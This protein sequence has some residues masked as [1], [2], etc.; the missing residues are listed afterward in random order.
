MSAKVQKLHEE[1]STM[2]LSD[3][4]LLAHQAV[5]FPMPDEKLDLILKYVEMAISMR[6]IRKAQP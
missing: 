4:L 1:M 3:I 6:R 5:N 2:S